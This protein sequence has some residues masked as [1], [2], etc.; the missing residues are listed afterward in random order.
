MDFKFPFELPQ[1][2]VHDALLPALVVNGQL[3][4]VYVVPL[5]AVAVNAFS[6][7]YQQDNLSQRTATH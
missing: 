2:L 6:G 5:P 3:C 4:C 7:M 1:F